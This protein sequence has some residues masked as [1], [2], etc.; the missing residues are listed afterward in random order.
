MTVWSY[1]LM[2]VGA[3]ILGFILLVKLFFGD[4]VTRTRRM[5][6]TI[7]VMVIC[8][9]IAAFIRA[10]TQS[11]TTGFFYSAAVFA[12]AGVIVLVVWLLMTMAGAA[13]AKKALT[14]WLSAFGAA[15]VCVL[16][17]L[18][19]MF[20]INPVHIITNIQIG[21]MQAAQWVAAIWTI[22]FWISA[23]LRA[24][25]TRNNPKKAFRLGAVG[26]ILW[27]AITFGPWLYDLVFTKF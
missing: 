12:A 22:F 9:A 19:A 27:L 6:F 8:I 10:Q 26:F 5:T 20:Q 25:F 24:I 2:L 16:M 23:L 15:L 11:L 14:L 18:G 3:A 4:A 13:S 17:A 1:Q 21:P 7:V